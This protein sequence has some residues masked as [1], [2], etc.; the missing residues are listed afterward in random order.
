LTQV[1]VVSTLQERAHA[2]YVRFV[3]ATEPLVERQDALGAEVVAALRA[4]EDTY[5]A[6]DARIGKLLALPIEGMGAEELVRAA[7]H[8]HG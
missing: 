8:I 1:D 5:Q 6:L 2:S 7:K 4:F 3:A